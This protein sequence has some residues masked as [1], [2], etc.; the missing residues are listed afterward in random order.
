MKQSNLFLPLSLTVSEI[1]RYLRQLFESDDVLRNVWVQG[2]ISN[3]SRPASGHIYFTLKDGTAA[4]K[5]VIWRS[6]ATQLPINLQTGQAIE[7]H[8]YISIYDQ[9]GQYQLYVDNVRPAGEGALYQAFIRLKSQLESEGLFDAERK[10]PIPERPGHIGIVTSGTG[11][12]LQDMLNTIRTRYPIAA[13]TLAPCAVQGE[14]APAEIVRAINSLNAMHPEPDVILI[15]RG[16]GSL[17]DLWAF[18]DEDVVRAI[19]A[20]RIS[21]IS[22]VGHETD[23][24]LADFAA[25]LRAPTPTGAAVQ[26]TPDKTDLLTSLEAFNSE[27]TYLLDSRLTTHRNQLR[28]IQHT[29]QNQSPLRKILND[30]QRLD[31]FL[32]QLQ[33]S[34]MYQLTL[35][36]TRNSGI[37]DRLH[38]LAPSA[39]LKRGYAIIQ[40][41]QGKII[42]SV[43]QTQPA[44][45]IQIT[46]SDGT[47]NA[48]VKQAAQNA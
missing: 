14:K 29:L 12:A 15:A 9:G 2:E 38:A 34:M 3:L 4:L 35:R 25:D 10:K 21:T 11:A 6:M 40:D 23:F 22:G 43:H 37:T 18:N 1:T 36:K 39:I 41:A 24:T 32:N 47:I 28:E 44:D 17:E 8:G 46:V 26:A 13:V 33:R 5:C 20:S 42:K 30:Q 7:A 48:E 45:L 31:E 16:G 19:A 27:M